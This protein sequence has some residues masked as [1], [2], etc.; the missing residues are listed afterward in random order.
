MRQNE[1]IVSL[2]NISV[3]FDGETVLDDINL[4]IRNKEFITLLGPSGCGKTTT[5]RT[6]IKLYNPAGGNVYFKGQRIGAGTRSYKD[7]IAK[8]KAEAEAKAKADLEAKRQAAVVEAFNFLNS[9]YLNGVIYA[10]AGMIPV[11]QSIID[12]TELVITENVEAWKAMAQIDG[13][14]PMFVYPD[15]AIQLEGDSYAT[16]F[17]AFVHGDIEWSDDM[18]ADLSLKFNRARQAAITQEITEI[19]AGS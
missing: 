5:G 10:N 8:A 3:A 9:D 15:S 12:S 7:A 11:K 1:N 13:Y 19:V 18:I 4:D 17:S 6:I 16:T 14:A 2:K